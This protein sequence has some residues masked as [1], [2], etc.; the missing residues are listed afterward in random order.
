MEVVYGSWIRFPPPNDRHPLLSAVPRHSGHVATHPK[1][2]HPDLLEFD[3]RDA[4]IF[5]LKRDIKYMP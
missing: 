4:I 1:A 3:R 2:F 5:R